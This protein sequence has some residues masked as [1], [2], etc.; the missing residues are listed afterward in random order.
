MTRSRC[1]V[2]LA[3]ALLALLLPTAAWAQPAPEPGTL[4]AL[5]KSMTSEE[6][7]VRAK[8]FQDLLAMGT[9]GVEGLLGLLADPGQA[10][11]A[12]IEF[13]LHGMAAHFSRPG[14][15][16]ERAALARTLAE[17]L[18]G[19]APP[20]AKRFVIT[21]L[22]VC[23]R[24]EAVPALARCLV[25][26]ELA[27]SAR[28]A[29][30][31]NRSSEAARALREALP[32][33]TG[34]FRAAICQ[35]LGYR[36]DPEA[37]SLLIAEARGNDAAV[38]AAALAALGRIGDLR[39]APV[40]AAALGKGDDRQQRAAF[41]AYLLLAERLLE[42]EKATNALSIY[43]NALKSATTGAQKCA[44][45]VGI[46]K[47][48]SAE[49]VPVVLP[50]LAD[51]DPRVRQGA[52]QCLANMPDPKTS[53]ALAEAMKNAQ[54]S[55]KAGLLRV[56]AQREEPAAAQAIEAAT[57]DPNAEVRVTAYELLNR[58]DDPA[59]EDTLLEAATDGSPG[60]HAVALRA[61][62][63]LA[64]GRR[65]NEPDVARAMYSRALDLAKEDLLKSA[66]LRGLASVPDVGLLPKVEPMLQNEAVRGDALAAYVAIAAK[67]ADEGQEDRAIE[68][69]KGALE[70]SPPRDVLDTA[71]AELRDLGIKIDPA[72]AAGFITTWW[73]LGPL[74]GADVDRE[75]GPEKGVDLTASVAANGRDVPWKQH[76]TTDASGIV[77]LLALM[78]PNQN[79]TAYLY[80]EVTVP[81]AQDILFKAGSDDGMILWLNGQQ[82][83]RA[84]DPRSLQV[85][86]DTIQARLNAGV[87]KV[88][89]KVVQGGG[90]WQCCLRL[91]NPDGRPIA[92]EQKEE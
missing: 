80:A 63:R 2:S 70:M 6:P 92:F 86:Q 49:S 67:L 45:L 81:Q 65:G 64:D 13:A 18:G 88:L 85:D 82:I 59:L 43:S 54:P 12:G 84:P 28:Q 46:G 73:L 31:V 20:A 40:I 41:D 61:Y 39:A 48:G 72:Q 91:T 22:Q 58:L 75:W 79:T 23:G 8:A 36:E 44:A 29:L 5:T 35:A 9:K 11:M 21:Q 24:Q 3:V 7:G 56:L 55:V 89:M 52:L 77:N 37:V 74:P 57:G 14:A 50:Y 71:I 78:D 38:R 62:M 27:E 1:S 87:S 53:D 76:H 10:D 17:Y 47:V 15:D 26:E 30:I 32:K 69:L 83:H 34:A 25:D 68:M 19:D 33:T 60:V 42:G 4:A 66:A 16:A 51:A 90:D